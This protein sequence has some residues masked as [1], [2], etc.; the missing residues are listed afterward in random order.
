MKSH[1][2]RFLSKS[3]GL[4]VLNMVN[5]TDCV[6][7][8]NERP[9]LLNKLVMPTPWDWTQSVH[10]LAHSDALSRNSHIGCCGV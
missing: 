2:Q 1:L 9:S 8:R 10:S 3:S 5:V 7:S 6:R 4:A